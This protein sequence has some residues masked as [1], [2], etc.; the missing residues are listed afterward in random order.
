MYAVFNQKD[1]QESCFLCSVDMFHFAFVV[2]R[3]ITVLLDYLV[4]ILRVYFG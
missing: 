3:A 2:F 4:S 1:G